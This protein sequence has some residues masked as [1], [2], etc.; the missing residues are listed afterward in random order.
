MN[1]NFAPGAVRWPAAAQVR[2]LLRLGPPPAS[3]PRVSVKYCAPHTTS[4]P[5][6]SVSRGARQKLARPTLRCKQTGRSPRDR[7]RLP[8]HLSSRSGPPAAAAAASAAPRARPLKTSVRT[9][10]SQPVLTA[11]LAPT[12]RGCILHEAV[13]SGLAVPRGRHDIYGPM[14]A[15]GPVRGTKFRM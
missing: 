8:P 11:K 13:V 5:L 1:I 2:H 6:I 15:A 14:R 12:R 10:E 9:P 7:D 4:G 3:G